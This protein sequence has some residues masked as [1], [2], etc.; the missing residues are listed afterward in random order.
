MVIKEVKAGLNSSRRY[1]SQEYF[2]LQS[3]SNV[4]WNRFPY[5]LEDAS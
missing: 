2:D 1:I 3:T 4:S 5:E